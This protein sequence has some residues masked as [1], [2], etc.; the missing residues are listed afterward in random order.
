MEKNLKK[1]VQYV[2]LNHF[3]VQQKITHCNEL[4]FNKINL[5]KFFFS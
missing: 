5:Q 4:Y 1:N 3:A 2:K